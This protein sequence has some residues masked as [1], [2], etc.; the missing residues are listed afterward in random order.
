MTVLFIAAAVFAALALATYAIFAHVE[1]RSTVRASLRQLEGYEVARVRDKQLLGS[2][3][4]R[5]GAPL[6]GG[7]VD[8]GRRLTPVGYTEKTR[9]KLVIA[10]KPTTEEYDRFL[11]I[12]VITIVAIIPVWILQAK[13]LHLH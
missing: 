2:L 11:A 10:G 13:L 6:F 9:K 5:V 12:R 4:D 1:E 8:L 7:I 3:G